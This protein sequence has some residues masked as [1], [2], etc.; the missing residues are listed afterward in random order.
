MKCDEAQ[1]LHGPYLDSELDT[2]TSLEIAQH[3][4]SCPECARLLAE[5]E[6][7]EARIM[8]GL[9]RGPRTTALWDKIERKVA[10]AASSASRPRPPA[11][12]S[13]GVLGTL[14]AQLRAGWQR[15]RWAWAGLAAVWVGILALNLA[16]RE[17]DAPLM[18]GQEAP[19]ASE[20]RFALK[21][22]QLLMVELAITSEPVPAA[23]PKA[24]PPSPHSERRMETLN[25]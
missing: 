16:A 2:K 24:A 6:K 3:L 22:K 21:Q 5:E 20:M 23:K 19:S 14:G 25:A 7:L 4:E 8:A 11:R 10:D 9:N 13:Q 1:T 12:V 18:A 15:S 17:P